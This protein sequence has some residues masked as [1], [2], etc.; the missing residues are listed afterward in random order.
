[1]LSKKNLVII[2]D[3]NILVDIIDDHRSNNLF[4]V[5]ENWLTHIIRNMEH[6]PKGKG[7]KF[8]ANTN[9]LKEYQTTLIRSGYN[10]IGRTISDIFKRS[11]YMK[12]PLDRKNGTYFSI[13]KISSSGEHRRTVRD[14]SDEK[15]SEI[16]DKVSKIKRWNDHFIIVATRDTTTKRDLET[17]L[18][19][20][21]RTSV[22]GSIWHLEKTVEC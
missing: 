10:D 5:L 2:L 1:M 8:V 4:Q 13:S 20:R 6:T 12:R 14:K 15:F 9:I 17:K 11:I 18:N 21:E 22:E 7:V 3:T 19:A 16:I